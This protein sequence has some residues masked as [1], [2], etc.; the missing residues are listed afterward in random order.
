M[1]VSSVD[2]AENLPSS[3][4]ELEQSLCQ[5]NNAL[6]IQWLGMRHQH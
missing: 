1:I 3:L 6:S 5:E 4:T 2:R